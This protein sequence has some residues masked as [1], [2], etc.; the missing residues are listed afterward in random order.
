MNIISFS[1]SQSTI[2]CESKHLFNQKISQRHGPKL[3]RYCN[4]GQN[5]TKAKL[6]W[7]IGTDFL[8]NY[9]MKVCKYE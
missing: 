6:K 5:V 8:M 7:K 3:F 4:I 9:V 1:L 2:K